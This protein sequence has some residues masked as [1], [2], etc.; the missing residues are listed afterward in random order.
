MARRFFF[1]FA[2]FSGLMEG[3]TSYKIFTYI[4][5]RAVQMSPTELRAITYAKGIA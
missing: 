1:F 2:T 5:V 3:L 4:R